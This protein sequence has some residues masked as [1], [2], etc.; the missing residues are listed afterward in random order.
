[1]C[2]QKRQLLLIDAV[3]ELV[4]DREPIH[5]KH[6]VVSWIDWQRTQ[7]KK[8]CNSMILILRPVHYWFCLN[9]HSGV[10]QVMFWEVLF[11]ILISL[12]SIPVVILTLEILLASLPQRQDMSDK[13]IRAT[14]PEIG[15][16][17]PAHNEESV[18]AK[19]L[20]QIRVQLNAADRLLVV[21]D[22]CDDKTADIARQSGAVVLERTN[23]A[24]IGKGF[25]LEY[26][27][28]YLA[29]SPP[30]V[31]IVVDADCIVG[32][33][34]IDR[35]ARL[36]VSENRPVQALYLMEND[37]DAPGLKQRVASFAW[38]V[39]NH[40]R[41][42]GLKSVGLP[43]HLMGSGMAF[44]FKQLDDVRLGSAN[45]VE[46][47][48][49]GIDLTAAGHPPLFCPDVKVTSYFPDAMQ[50]VKSQRRRWEHGHI[51]MIVERL[52]SLMLKSMI[53]RDY[54]LLF[55]ALDLSVPPLTLLALIVIAL[56]GITGVVMI[57]FGVN[58]PF[59]LS[60]I[61]LFLF[62]LAVLT[63]W[64]G[65]GR[66]ILSF[67]DVLSLP[68]HM[69]KKIPLYLQFVLDRQKKWIRT[70]RD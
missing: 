62:C 42:L 34:L 52:P 56:L 23:L 36:S 40:V 60:I 55:L 44:P 66:D 21:A 32:E 69:L 5:L 28:R 67:R 27:V 14:R 49:L 38:R 31:V 26:G 4:S 11:S 2:E 57:G 54:M 20:T 65:F 15:V 3:A 12:V 19:T 9:T 43:C 25:A 64:I 59:F 63:A 70:E 45:I 16:L 53:K 7:E 18:I 33:E 48:Q 50:A 39:K 46:D 51:G 35:I 22:N 61:T 17:V 13:E 58:T 37:S 29:E 6:A 1:L 8:C 47:M 24:N 30:D 41:P 68:V 10:D